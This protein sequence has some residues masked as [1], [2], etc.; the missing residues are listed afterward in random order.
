M[1]PNPGGWLTVTAWRKAVDAHRADA[2]RSSS[3]DPQV[4]SE[5]AGAAALTAP[6]SA[7][8]D[9][10]ETLGDDRLGLIFACCTRRSRSRCASR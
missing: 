5:V 3:V 2:A 1:P 8:A 6:G 9:M 10:T 7:E 4:L